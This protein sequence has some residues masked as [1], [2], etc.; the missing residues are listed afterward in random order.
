M[1]PSS[2]G[3]IGAWACGQGPCG[4]GS[5]GA[6]QLL[7]NS[8]I[9]KGGKTPAYQGVR[10]GMKIFHLSWWVLPMVSV[11]TAAVIAAVLGCIVSGFDAP[12]PFN[13]G[14]Y[15]SAEGRPAVAIILEW[16]RELIFRSGED[17]RNFLRRYG[18][19]PRD[20]QGSEHAP[21]TRAAS[22]RECF[23]AR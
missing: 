8:P 20:E 18:F 16:G 22:D 3:A 21:V 19:G 6:D 10:R 15:G 14:R 17:G 4:A 12:Q 9:D 23:R 13:R 11:G 1:L 2:K 5:E 7:G